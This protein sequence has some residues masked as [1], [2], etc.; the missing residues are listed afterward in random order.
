MRLTAFSLRLSRLA[1]LFLPSDAFSHNYDLP[2]LL[3]E[4]KI[5]LYCIPLI[6]RISSGLGIFLLISAGVAPRSVSRAVMLGWRS[7]AAGCFSKLSSLLRRC[8]RTEL[9][10]LLNSVGGRF[11]AKSQNHTVLVWT[12]A[13]L[14]CWNHKSSKT[15]CL[16]KG[17]DHTSSI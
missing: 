6:L 8:L 13:L 17:S 4:M 2:S 14:I 16:F 9:T 3:C 12:S 11:T 7:N 5:L 1:F 15:L 10:W